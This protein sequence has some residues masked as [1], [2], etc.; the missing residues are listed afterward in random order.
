MKYIFTIAITFTLVVV[1]AEADSMAR[2]KLI[3]AAKERVRKVVTDGY[4]KARKA[5]T[6]EILRDLEDFRVRDPDATNAEVQA[7]VNT[8]VF[9]VCKKGC[10]YYGRNYGEFQP[11]VA[12]KAA[13]AL[14]TRL[15][16]DPSTSKPVAAEALDSLV[17]V[18]ANSE[19][20][21]EAE[22]RAKAVIAIPAKDADVNA[23]PW[24]ALMRV[25]RWWDRYDQAL[26]A[27]REACRI[28]PNRVPDVVD[29]A[30]SFGRHDDAIALWKEFLDETA[31]F[32]Y[33]TTHA[34]RFAYGPVREKVYPRLRAF[35]RNVKIPVEK[36][37]NLA[38]SLGLFSPE[39][40]E[41]EEDRALFKGE[42][43]SQKKFNLGDANYV[44]RA[45]IDG[46]WA[47][48][49]R[50]MDAF[51]TVAKPNLGTPLYRRSYAMAL[52]YQGRD[53]DALTALGK[54]KTEKDLKPL[55]RAR[56]AAL[57]AVLC[58]QDAVKAVE[59][60]RL[61]VT[62]RA[63]ALLLPAQF[64][65]N[66]KRNGEAHRYTAAYQACFKEIPRRRVEVPFFAKGVP[67][68][69]AWRAIRS[70]LKPT[71]VDVKVT[72]DLE[73]LE[74]DVATGR[75]AV[76][77]TALDSGDAKMEVTPLCDAE[78]LHIFLCV[79]DKNARAVEEGFAGGIG[80]EMYFAPGENQPYICFGT[81]PRK[82]IDF[83]FNTAYSSLDHQRLRAMDAPKGPRTIRCDVAFT[84]EDYVC[85][86]CFPWTAFYQKLP[87]KAGTAW[88]FDCLADGYSW[89]GVQTV[90]EPSRWGDLVFNLSPEQL[91]AIR[92]RL[93]V[94]TY[95]SWNAAPEGR[96]APFD[97]WADPVLGD[98][99]FYE[100]CL[101]PLE[102][103]L[104][105]YS[106]RVK[107]EMTDAD[108]NEIFVKGVQ[109]WM[110]LKYEIAE[111]RRKYLTQKQIGGKW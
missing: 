79:R 20:F 41:A 32:T 37:F 54:A 105:G 38:S 76:E 46:R 51:S 107:P 35:V 57:E 25:Y 63:E 34:G 16:D 28:K 59:A 108:V 45:Y 69:T 61:P 88:K 12:T 98:P 55:D 90:H 42:D 99:E 14:A 17:L 24:I 74:T 95:K 86:L 101:K 80:T 11:E 15:L 100:A 58:R 85:H 89:G 83:E 96:C 87:A 78:G 64:T 60:F 84:D 31:E 43:L 18:L 73:F 53:K 3:S 77:K 82:G 75:T 39:T 71:F 104:K 56:I 106:A 70:Q 50:L 109:R 30:C 48:F 33:Y 66:L 27:G 65:L 93:V 44:S 4:S 47:H 22:N 23:R 8:V 102:A 29:M 2:L 10:I 94:R 52:A 6:S 110:G 1:S 49:T 97:E 9:H 26:E 36:R 68:I 7:Y 92:R 67:D 111:L 19:R 13:E 72:G 81:S 91:T 103:E 21:A 5:S 62:E 40:P